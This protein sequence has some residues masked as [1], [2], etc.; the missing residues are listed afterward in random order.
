[1]NLTFPASGFSDELAADDAG[2][3]LNAAELRQA[4][5][6]F[7]QIDDRCRVLA[8]GAGLRAASPALQPGLRLGVLFSVLTAAGVVSLDEGLAQSPQR[9]TLVS[10]AGAPLQLSGQVLSQSGGLLLLLTPD[11]A[12]PSDAGPPHH[13]DLL[14]YSGD[15]WRERALALER[16]LELAPE[17]V[18]HFDPT[19]ILRHCNAALERL[20]EMPRDELL[21][22]SLDEV[23]GVLQACLQAH[24]RESVLMPLLGRARHLHS[25]ADAEA[26]S[27]LIELVLPLRKTVRVSTR[28][29][30]LGD[31]VFYLSE[32]RA[33]EPESDTEPAALASAHAPFMLPVAEE[34]FD[35][36]PLPQ[37][38]IS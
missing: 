6:F 8:L 35:L 1:M 25:G 16:V 21:G 14:D 15:D 7:I 38:V 10:S 27:S 11:A 28:C 36:L 2:P 13:S 18:L 32:A 3:A 4:F 17:G 5:P 31:V 33:A 37:V 9:L 23:D 30:A 29:D 22:Q 26:A 24:Q 34:V 20:L 19:G 12:T